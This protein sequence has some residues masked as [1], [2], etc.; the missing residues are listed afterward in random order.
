MNKFLAIIILV[1]GLMVM[2]SPP[3]IHSFVSEEIVI[4]D[5]LCVDGN[6]N[7]NLDGVMCEKT[8]ITTF[9]VLNNSFTGVLIMLMGFLLLMVGA[10]IMIYGFEYLVFSNDALVSGEER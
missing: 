2:F 3:I 9:G 1:F 8:E 10:I 5:Q 6:K 7:I 4:G